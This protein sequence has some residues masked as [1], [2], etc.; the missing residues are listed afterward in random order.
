MKSISKCYRLLDVSESCSD[1]ELKECYLKL[2]K[3]S[4]PDRDAKSADVA[5]FVEIQSAYNKIVVR[6]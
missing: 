3:S 6:I 5:K 4:H 2:V 1:D